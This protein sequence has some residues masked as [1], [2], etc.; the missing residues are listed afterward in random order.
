MAPPILSHRQLH[1]AKMKPNN[2][3]SVQVSSCRLEKGSCIWNNIITIHFWTN[4]ARY[5][6]VQY[7]YYFRRVIRLL[8]YLSIDQLVFW[9]FEILDFASRFCCIKFNKTQ[10]KIIFSFWWILGLARS[11]HNFS[12]STE[13]LFLKSLIKLQ[14][15]EIF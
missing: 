13:R 15:L 4:I 7:L 1:V 3:C 9:L 10:N 12:G 2:Y 6:A 8:V 14:V 5:L 11:C